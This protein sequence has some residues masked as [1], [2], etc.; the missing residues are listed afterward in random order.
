MTHGVVQ[1]IPQHLT[2]HR[3]IHVEHERF[4]A[5][6]E[7]QV[8]AAYPAQLQDRLAHQ[9]PDVDRCQVERPAHRFRAVPRAGSPPPCPP[10]GRCCPR[11]CRRSTAARRSRGPGLFG[12]QLRGAFDEGERRADLVG[13]EP[14]RGSL[15]AG[16]RSLVPQCRPRRALAACAAR[17]GPR[18]SALPAARRRG[19]ARRAALPRPAEPVSTPRQDIRRRLTRGPACRSARESDG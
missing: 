1:E 7:V 19:A 12:E 11:S 2:D 8:R 3:P 5:A 14:G 9:L 18:P 15:R 17:G 10:P 6:V 4:T 16:F 13:E